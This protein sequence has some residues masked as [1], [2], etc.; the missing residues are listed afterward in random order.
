VVAHLLD[1]ERKLFDLRAEARSGQK[2]QL[3]ERISQLRE[4]VGGLVEQVEA[5]GREI[6]F[7]QEEL[8]GVMQLWEKNL[9]PITRVTALKRDAARLEG[10]RGQLVAYKAS[11]AGKI[12][13]TELQ[14]IQ[15]DEDVRSKVRGAQRRARQDLGAQRTQDLGRVRAR[16]HRHPFAA[17]RPGSPARSAH[18]WRRD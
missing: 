12:S 9:V 15:V 16:S 4:E 8:K 17:N 18:G 2:K 3:K 14:I 7:I 10:E 1:G 5:K 11:T 13:E 6:A